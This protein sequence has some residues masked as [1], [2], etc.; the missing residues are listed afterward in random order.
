MMMEKDKAPG[1]GKKNSTSLALQ[2][3]DYL[4]S[5]LILIQ[6]NTCPRHVAS[7]ATLT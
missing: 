6:Q 7:V 3:R 5:Q 4:L 1:P 2:S